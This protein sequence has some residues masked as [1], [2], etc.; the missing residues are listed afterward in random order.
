[1]NMENKKLL[2]PRSSQNIPEPSSPALLPTSPSMNSDL[3]YHHIPDSN[4]SNVIGQLRK[5]LREKDA[6]IKSLQEQARNGFP[7]IDKL[8][9][10][11]LYSEREANEIKNQQILGILC[12]K[13]QQIANLTEICDKSATVIK[14]LRQQMFNTNSELEKSNNQLEHLKELNVDTKKVIELEDSVHVL[15][16][17][18][19]ELL[20]KNQHLEQK[21][22]LLLDGELK[23]SK[24]RRNNRSS[25]VLLSDS[26]VSDDSKVTSSKDGESSDKFSEHKEDII[27][28]LYIKIQGLKRMVSGKQD[29]II[30]LRNDISELPDRVKRDME[31]FDLEKFLKSD[32]IQDESTLKDSRTNQQRQKSVISRLQMA[33]AR[34]HA[35]TKVLISNH[36]RDLGSRGKQITELRHKLIKLS[37]SN[38][39]KGMSKVLSTTMRQMDEEMNSPSRHRSRSTSRGRKGN[40]YGKS[41]RSKSSRGL[42]RTL[43]SESNTVSKS[44][45]NAML[46]D[47]LEVLENKQTRLHR[48]LYDKQREIS[49]LQMRLGSSSADFVRAKTSDEIIG[50]EATLNREKG[51]NKN[52]N[53]QIKSLQDREQSA[54][55]RYIRLQ[56]ESS[57]RETK[58]K[59]ALQSMTNLA[60]EVQKSASK[61]ASDAINDQ[62]QDK[63]YITTTTIT[64]TTSIEDEATEKAPKENVYDRF[65]EAACAKL[66]IEMI[67]LQIRFSDLQGKYQDLERANLVK[68]RDVQRSFDRFKKDS[69]IQITSAN[70]T[71][72]SFG[73]DK[74]IERELIK[75]RENNCKLKRN[76]GQIEFKLK[77]YRI[78]TDDK[79]KNYNK[80]SDDIDDMSKKLKHYNLLDTIYAEKRESDSVLIRMADALQD[81]SN[82][83]VRLQGILTSMRVG[84]QQQNM[85]MNFGGSNNGDTRHIFASNQ[86][87]H[88]NM[89]SSVDN[90]I[91]QVRQGIFISGRDDSKASSNIDQIKGMLSSIENSY[92]NENNSVLSKQDAF[93]LYH[94]LIL[95]VA[96]ER[97]YLRIENDRMSL[98]CQKDSQRIKNL[99]LNLSNV[100]NSIDLK[101][102][103]LNRTSEQMNDAIQGEREKSDTK[104]RKLLKRISSY[105]REVSVSKERFNK[106]K[107]SLSSVRSEKSRVEKASYEE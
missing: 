52:L 32:E 49:K 56:R 28:S 47:R 88:K 38:S 18:K 46:L 10:T 57:D 2:L 101:Q 64:T 55:D 69:E 91:N 34:L 65:K 100:E 35:Y 36:E 62:K 74:D 94:K 1:M 90:L 31:K 58:L 11:V 41:P 106:L 50:L 68:M 70:E 4:T 40:K 86:I 33:L 63:D 98:S 105:D 39:S 77:Q 44:L 16:N 67:D 61:M 81:K 14:E 97:D 78:D 30:Q 79:V 19:E 17:E 22:K 99:E 5:L 43:S 45:N 53:G 37:S 75:I 7:D 51:L 27:A 73:Q 60:S 107:R 42:K 29:E 23:S 103:E 87:E 76:I 20:V 54:I 21:V 85:N 82:E 72:S 96:D 8:I 92:G 84:S 6:Q 80:M 89:P 83:I 66:R 48:E 9:E 93:L 13:D 25:K 15:K 26:Q 102:S 24:I 12:Q 59:E 71:L 104:C 95:C 3:H